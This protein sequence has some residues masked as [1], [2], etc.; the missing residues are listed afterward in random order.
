MRRPPG[1]TYNFAFTQQWDTYKSSETFHLARAL[2]IAL[3]AWFKCIPHRTAFQAN[4]RWSL[5]IHPSPKRNKGMR[6]ATTPKRGQHVNWQQPQYAY[7]R[8]E[9]FNPWFTCVQRN[10]QLLFSPKC[11]N[12]Y[13]RLANEIS[14][15]KLHLDN[16][17]FQVNYDPSQKDWPG[18][19]IIMWCVHR[20]QLLYFTG[21]VKGLSWGQL[22]PGVHNN[23]FIILS[24]H[25]SMIIIIEGG[26]NNSRPLRNLH[27]P[28]NYYSAQ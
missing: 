21:W 28:V 1:V 7:C 13:I 11:V 20:H 23:N 19:K 5:S 25:S 24:C 10:D 16:Y 18:N 15:D 4:A 12:Y 22:L 26:R 2:K 8:S 3:R 27:P 14:Y 6:L 17:P 9:C